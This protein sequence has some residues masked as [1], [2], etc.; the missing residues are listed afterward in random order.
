MES[1][2]FNAQR[3]RGYLQ[4]DQFR[5]HPEVWAR[6]RGLNIDLHDALYVLQH[7]TIATAPHFD[8]D[9]EKWRFTIQGE[10]LD[11]KELRIDFTFVE[12]DSVLVLAVMDQGG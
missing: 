11:Q 7:G 10:T 5:L 9:I 6:L 8:P 2:R 1:E 4:K 12:V 3:L